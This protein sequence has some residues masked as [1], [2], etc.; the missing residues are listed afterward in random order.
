MLP[1]VN[2]DLVAQYIETGKDYKAR[3]EAGESQWSSVTAEINWN[4]VRNIS[5][6]S[7]DKAVMT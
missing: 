6:A 3:Q 5:I 4:P 7:K 2:N 1:N